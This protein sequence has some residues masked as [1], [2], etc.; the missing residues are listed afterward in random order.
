[1]IINISKSAL[2]ICMICYLSACMSDEEGSELFEQTVDPIVTS[3]P[4]PEPEV[5]ETPSMLTQVSIVEQFG[6]PL[7]IFVNPLEY[8][9]DEETDLSLLDFQ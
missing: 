4:E 6:N 1:M 5:E 7:R 3:S 8:L 9:V 2:W